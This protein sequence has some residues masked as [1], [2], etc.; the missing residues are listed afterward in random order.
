MNNDKRE[1]IKKILIASV[2]SIS[3]IV[4][5]IHYFFFSIQRFDGQELLETS[6]S[7]DNR[8]T[9]T[10][11]LNNGGATVDYAVLCTVTD[12][13]TGFKH[14]IY[15]QYHCYDAE[16][17]WS[18]ETTVIINDIVLNVKKDIYDWRDQ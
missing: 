10:A 5:G 11:Y 18:D 8:Y 12:N 4:L 16:I 17:K 13:K 6:V 15:W 2:V 3:I 7:P 14:N 1:F 9:V